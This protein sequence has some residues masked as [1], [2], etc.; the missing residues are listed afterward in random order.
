MNAL[1]KIILQSAL[2]AA[3][4]GLA[5]FLC[6]GIVL[7]GA[8]GEDWRV[9]ILTAPISSAAIAVVSWRLLTA[10]GRNV[11]VWKGVASGV[12]AGS[13][14]HFF[15]WYLAIICFYVRGTVASDGSPI[16][17]LADG[18]GAS[19]IMAF[20]SLAVLGWITIPV[21]AAVGGGLAWGVN[22]FLK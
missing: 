22:R 17:G 16:L 8:G 19:F 20:F 5:A 14:S 6:A 4:F 18:L 7:A 12:L 11:R 9:L 21:G 1:T 10:G 15:A 13:V 2:C 3:A